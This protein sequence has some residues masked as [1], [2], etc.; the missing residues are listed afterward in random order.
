[1]AKLS[2]AVIAFVAIYLA[3]LI[4]P[5]T[6]KILPPTGYLQPSTDVQLLVVLS[7][8]VVGDTAHI[9]HQLAQKHE[10]RVLDTWHIESLARDCVILA[11]KFSADVDA[12]MVLLNG[13]SAIES[14]QTMRFFKVAGRTQ[15]LKPD[16]YAQLQHSLINARIDEAHALSTG[17]D[18][19]V[20]IIDTGLDRSNVD[21]RDRIA[22]TLNFVDAD[23][24]IE[25]VEFHA[26]AVAG[27]IGAAG[28]NGRGIVGIAPNSKMYALRACWESN[29]GVSRGQC[30]SFALA[31]ALDWAISN[32]MKVVNMSLQGEYDPLVSRLIVRAVEQG[33]VVVAATDIGEGQF[34]FPAS[35]NEVIA[36]TSNDSQRA[37][38]LT[39]SAGKVFVAPGEE[40]LT[41]MPDNTFDFVSGSS[42]AS[43]HIS[44]IV[45]L[46]AEHV[47]TIDAHTVRAVLRSSTRIANWTLSID[48]CEALATVTGA[49]DCR[50]L[51]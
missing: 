49:E 18:V 46:L 14:V 32:D 10:L 27:I 39:R 19:R 48:A 34:S 45:A 7:P 20:A 50:P 15:A 36:V 6:A 24:T 1:M 8:A 43:A 41:T 51:P 16:P 17:K 40:V 37:V 35:M 3:S 2:L 12:K 11:T 22:G 30:S 28:N 42:F 31:R 23:Q 47:P 21:L 25:I 9:A 13:E 5:G 4:Q 29:P 26:T 38:D 33:L 44:G